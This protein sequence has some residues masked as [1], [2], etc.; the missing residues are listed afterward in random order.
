MNTEFINIIMIVS[1][2]ACVY[3]LYK[4][5]SLLEKEVGELK[6]YV[7]VKHDVLGEILQ[8]PIPTPMKSNV[9]ENNNQTDNSNYIIQEVEDDIDSNLDESEDRIQ[10]V[11]QEI[12]QSTLPND[13]TIVDL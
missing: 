2:T 12:D 8:I 10:E 1:L 11:E 3:M 5:I 4:E 7:H 13:S 9:V 6:K